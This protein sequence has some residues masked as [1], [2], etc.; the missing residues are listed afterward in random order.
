MVVK[1]SHTFAPIA[2]RYTPPSRAGRAGC[3]TADGGI[4]GN[5]ALFTPII[6]I[7]GQPPAIDSMIHMASM[8]LL[9]MLGA[10]A[11]TQPPAKAA[12]I[13]FIGFSRNEA[14]CAWRLHVNSVSGGIQDRY[15]LVH[16]VE[17]KSHKLIA[18]FRDSATI[19]RFDAH[20]K[21]IAAASHVL[22]E[23]HPDWARAGSHALW[24]RLRQHGGF[25]SVQVDFKSN[26]I[27]VL[28]DEDDKPL[29]F[30]A[31]KKIL[32]I[33]TRPGAPLGYQAVARL[34][35]G[36][37]LVLGHY[38]MDAPSDGAAHAQLEVYHS[39]A[40]HVIAV[41]N[42]FATAAS[43]A[44]NQAAFFTTPYNNPIGSTNIGS[45]NMIETDSQSVES[46]Y[47]EMRPQGAHDYDVFVGRWF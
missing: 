20:G 17:I 10:P 18:V 4:V 24:E 42:R 45:L 33:T 1:R 30:S 9:T 14:A 28:P 47:K 16:V 38:R 41:V 2:A 26:L 31:K 34:Y 35:Q 32:N 36:T 37:P 15:S 21:R 8:V 39:H 25:G 23:A 40:G 27:R 11:A 7:A 3:R 19:Q 13:D 5:R 6:L 46:L 22:A 12:P 29:E 44:E 43:A